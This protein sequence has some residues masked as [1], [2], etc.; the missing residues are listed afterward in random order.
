MFHTHVCY[1]EPVAVGGTSHDL[2][3]ARV[4]CPSPRLGL[5]LPVCRSPH[6]V[7]GSGA[8][9]PVRAERRVGSGV[10]LV[11]PCV[12]FTLTTPELERRGTTA[13]A[14]PVRA[15]CVLAAPRAALSPPRPCW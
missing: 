8:E 4:S 9:W 2:S 3:L 1:S 11:A 7:P 5:P 14:C 12:C 10:A 13:V 6:D 15:P